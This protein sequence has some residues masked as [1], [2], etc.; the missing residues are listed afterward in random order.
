MPIHASHGLWANW[1]PGSSANNGKNVTLSFLN[2]IPNTR[3]DSVKSKII[4]PRTSGQVPSSKSYLDI[5][6][7]HAIGSAKSRSHYFCDHRQKH[8]W[9]NALANWSLIPCLNLYSV[10]IKTNNSSKITVWIVNTTS[11]VVNSI[12][13]QTIRVQT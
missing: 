10:A 8:T 7:Y 3:Y 5:E 6:Y 13:C 1:W 4:V 9:D 2:T 11:S 12:S